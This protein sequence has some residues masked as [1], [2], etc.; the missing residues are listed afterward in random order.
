[1]NTI[2]IAHTAPF[3]FV[4]FFIN[5]QLVSETYNTDNASIVFADALPVN[6][7]IEFKPHKIKPIVRYN[8]IMLDYWLANILLQDHKIQMDITDTFFQDYK[9]KNI[10]GRIASL[11]PEQKN[12]EHFH[13][14]YIGINNQHQDL[15]DQIKSLIAQ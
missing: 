5:N 7:E 6:L 1:M 15:V 9:N 14:K 13:D 10:E 11:P 8:N 12:V 3:E 4:K 2:E